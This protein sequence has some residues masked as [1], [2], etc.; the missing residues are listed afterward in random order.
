MPKPS[1]KSPKPYEATPADPASSHVA[2]TVDAVANL[3]AQH[4]LKRSVAEKLID[5]WTSRLARPF[6]LAVLFL[7]VAAWIAMNALNASSAIDPPPFPWLFGVLAFLSLTMGVLI[8]ST[9]RRADALAQLREQLTL[10]LATLT[11]R[12]V[13]KVIELIEELRRDS[14]NIENRID[15][16]AKQMAA[17][18]QPGEMLGA[19]AEM[20]EES[21]KP[22]KTTDEP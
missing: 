20:H 7:A 1:T 19:L 14:P 17:Q 2:E 21:L 12:K 16:E 22:A 18:A 5:N 4:H 15:L 9:Q 13:T 8:L 11:E 10:N 6:S 3:H